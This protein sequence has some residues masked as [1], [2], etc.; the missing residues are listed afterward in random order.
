M[1]SH[2]RV[3]DLTDGGSSMAGRILADLGAQVILLEPPE[4]KPRIPL[5]SIPHIMCR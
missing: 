2:L 3:L 5:S 4:N 1:L